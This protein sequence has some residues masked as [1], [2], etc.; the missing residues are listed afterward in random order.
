[1]FFPLRCSK[2]FPCINLLIFTIKHTADPQRHGEIGVST[3]ALTAVSA[4][5]RLQLRFQIQPPALDLPVYVAL[6]S[7]VCPHGPQFSSG[8]PA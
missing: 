7:F 2:S 3:Q 6:G 4:R 1:M 8:H 5:L